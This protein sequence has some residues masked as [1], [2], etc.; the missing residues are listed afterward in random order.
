MARNGAYFAIGRRAPV[1]ILLDADE[2]R[3]LGFLIGRAGD[4][5]FRYLMPPIFTLP[6]I[7]PYSGNIISALDFRQLEFDMPFFVSRRPFFPWTKSISAIVVAMKAGVSMSLS[8]LRRRF[9]GDFADEARRLAWPR[10]DTTSRFSAANFI[11]AQC[12]ARL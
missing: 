11:G 1:I 10:R 5:L 9:R 4:S 8:Q 3:E 6:I 12:H 7:G 2:A